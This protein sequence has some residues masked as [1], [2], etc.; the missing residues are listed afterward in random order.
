MLPNFLI[1]GAEKA[2][3]SS[4]YQYL[5]AHPQ[6]FMPDQKELDFFVEDMNW[7]RGL[8][9]YER[10]F[11]AAG[12]A[13]AIGEASTNYTVYPILRGVPA[14]IAEVLPDSRLIYLVR[15]PIERMISYAMMTLVIGERKRSFTDEQLLTNVRYLDQ[16]RYAMQIEQYLEFF[17]RDRLLIV[18]SEDLRDARRPTMERVFAFLGVDGNSIPQNLD[19]EYNAARSKAWSKNMRAV[20]PTTLTMS[21][22]LRRIPGYKRLASA[23]PSSMRN[24]KRRIGTRE[25][26]R[27]LTISNAVRRKLEDRLRPDI[28]RLRSYM[29]EDF[30]GWGI[31]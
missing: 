25:V 11:E 14:R 9:W 15:H 10:Q 16:S 27:T 7:N 4:L 24:A 29:G 3:T 1:I 17:P 13:L 18:K 21:R 12:D 20:R 30:D 19:V 5:R 23:A 28:E 31:G 8:D 22:A 6:V 2:G 26:R